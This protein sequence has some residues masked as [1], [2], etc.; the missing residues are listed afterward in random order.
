V[1]AHHIA[2]VA[3]QH[4][5]RPLGDAEIIE[6][7]QNRANTVVDLRDQAEIFLLDVS[8]TFA[9][10]EFGPVKLLSQPIP[11]YERLGGAKGQ[12]SYKRFEV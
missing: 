9:A 2:V 12:I 1:A 6:F 11:Q 8:I 4:G 7:C 3:R 10:A 5:D